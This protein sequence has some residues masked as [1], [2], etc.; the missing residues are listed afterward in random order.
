MP[1][2][3]KE[4]KARLM[5]AGVTQTEIADRLGVTVMHV[6]HV[7]AGRRRSPRVEQAVADAIGSPP[8]RVFPKYNPPP[9][10]A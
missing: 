6:S 1:L 4:R 7:I 10:A 8:N 9:R 3:A 5:L 2:S